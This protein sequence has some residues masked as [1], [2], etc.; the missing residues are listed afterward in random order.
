MNKTIHSGT[1][2]DVMKKRYQDQEER[3][4]AR[5]AKLADNVIFVC[6]VVMIVLLITQAATNGTL[7]QVIR[8]LALTNLG[9]MT[10]ALFYS[11][12]NKN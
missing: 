6:F 10:I 5:L 7:Q 12:N 4:A 8:V 3:K 2:A 9:I 1:L 11:I